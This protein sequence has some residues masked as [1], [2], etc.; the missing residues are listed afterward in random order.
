MSMLRV[1]S[2]LTPV[3]AGD[4]LHLERFYTDPAGPPVFLLHGVI[5]NARVWYSKSNKG[6][7]PWLARLGYDVYCGDLRGHGDSTPPIGRKTKYGQHEAI[8]EDIPTLLA[9]VER[10]RGAIGQHWIAHSWGGV[11]LYSYLAR[12]VDH[13][14]RVR[15]ITSFGTKRTV[16]VS[17][18][19][20]LLKIDLA[21]HVG[22]SILDAVCGYLPARPLKMGSDNMTA[23]AHQDCRK[24]A[25]KDA[26]WVDRTDGFDYGAA[27]QK[28]A[29]PPSL[30]FAGSHDFS[31][32][33]PND[34]KAFMKSTGARDAQFHLLDGY[35]H[36]DMITHPDAES[37][38]YPRVAEW[39]SRHGEPTLLVK[40][41]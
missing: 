34:V 20:K 10:R 5:E 36:I 39:L 3:G 13:R 41:A 7:A 18:L 17:N 24:W 35:N 38:N 29:L 12:F 11:L 2:I 28:V 21:W 19:D 9:E 25:L 33:H 8:C 37:E 1:E 27:I 15:S 4:Q 16:G 30:F 40:Q 6:L 22:C 31:L 26:L 14:N 32:G 23:R